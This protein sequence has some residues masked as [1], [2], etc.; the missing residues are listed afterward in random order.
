LRF[1]FIITLMFSDP[2]VTKRQLGWLFVA[3]AL[4]LSLAAFGVH[5]V[6]AGLSG[7]FGPIQQQVLGGSLLLLV[8]GLSLLPR[9]HRP[10]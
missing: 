3:A 8:L 9:G 6:R 1:A 2:P 7:P 4:L 10:A 5:V